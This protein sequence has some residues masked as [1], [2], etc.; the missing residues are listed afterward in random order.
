MLQTRRS[1]R[2]NMSMTCRGYRQ[3]RA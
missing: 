3:P 1:S 2:M